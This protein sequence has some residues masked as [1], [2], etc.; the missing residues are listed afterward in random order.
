[1]PNL[2]ATYVSA[3]FI[4]FVSHSILESFKIHL[5]AIKFNGFNKGSFYKIILNEGLLA[6][7]A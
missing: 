6:F 5:F 2:L 4:I 1:M 7:L 3:N